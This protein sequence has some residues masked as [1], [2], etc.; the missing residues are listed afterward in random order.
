MEDFGK[1]LENLRDKFGY[2][3]RSL[4]QKLGFSP[5]VYGAYE[6]GERRP[7]FETMVKIADIFNVSLDY[8]IRG[9][10]FQSNEQLPYNEKA[11]TQVIDHFTKKGINEP[12]ILDVDK[13]SMLTTDDLVELSNHF[14]W[15][16]HKA[17][18]RDK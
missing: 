2:S 4:S 6:R 17:K 7:S 5:N 16:V 11:F 1:R 10:D 9:E 8:L 12:Y 15:V 13:W 3:K 14:E 18:M